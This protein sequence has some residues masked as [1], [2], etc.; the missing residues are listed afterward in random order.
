MRA[1]GP[2]IWLQAGVE[3]LEQRI[4]ADFVTAERRPNLTL[5]GGRR[6][7]E[8]TLSRREPLYRECAT[9]TI[10]TDELSIDAVVDRA[11]AVI[12]NAL[13]QGDNA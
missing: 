5:H 1:A 4:L 10:T 3:L 13:G 9:A 8:E 11:Y 12:Q 6:E 7:I 2:V